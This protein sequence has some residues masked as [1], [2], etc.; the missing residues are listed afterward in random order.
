MGVN[1]VRQE[2]VEKLDAYWGPVQ[3]SSLSELQKQ[4][5]TIR[6]FSAEHFYSTQQEHTG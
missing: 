6:V 3:R 1:P 4:E 5:D 2:S